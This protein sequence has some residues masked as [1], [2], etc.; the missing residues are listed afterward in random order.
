MVLIDDESPDQCP[1]ILD[2]Y[3][4]KDTRIKVIHQKNRGLSGARETGLKA[5]SG[6]YVN[7]VDSDDWIEDTAIEEMV[8][9]AE[10]NNADIVICDWK[11]FENEA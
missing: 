3:A 1:Q 5:A 8:E 2:E 9:A 7:F 6:K 11:T 10:K 4:K